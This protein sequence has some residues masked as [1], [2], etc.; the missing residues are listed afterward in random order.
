MSRL[1]KKP[2][3]LPKGVEVK[4]TADEIFV[5]GPKGQ[6]QLKLMQGISVQQEENE[7]KLSRQDSNDAYHGLY[8]S[9][10]NNLVVGVSQ[11][12]EKRLSLVGVGFRA[13]VSGNKLDL[14]IG[15][16]HP[17]SVEI[18]SDI[19]VKV[20]KG[21]TI[22]L[23]GPD[24]QKLGQLAAQIRAL[25]PPEPYKGKGIRYE[26]EYV[27]KKAGKAAKSK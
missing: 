19:Q 20:D 9:L 11:G 22:I 24:K 1:G 14:Q 7:L 16:S 21:T 17:T 3:P 8:R 27:R 4:L 23:V 13:A 12:F 6:L 25:R 26:G 10:I 18:P 2:I 15:F 5:K